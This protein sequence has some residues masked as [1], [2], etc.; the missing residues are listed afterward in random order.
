MTEAGTVLP[1]PVFW[2]TGLSGA[3]KTTIATS[4]AD[5]LQGAGRKVAILD[6]DAIRNSYD[7]PLGFTEAD[8]KLNNRL[9][10]EACAAARHDTDAVFVP[11]ISPYAES[12]VAARALLAPGFFEIYVCPPVVEL[13][14][15]DTKGLYAKARRGEM[16]NL[17]GY[18]PG[19]VYE[20]PDAPDLR[21]DTSAETVTES[22]K[23]LAA[24]AD[25]ILT[26]TAS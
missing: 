23:R 13:E 16:D 17:I 6:G 5:I 18:S 14:R 12:R 3:G 21:I 4:A 24:F 20:A 22:A 15:R 25:G 10:A 7:K 19:T 9:I 2:F 1:A 11:I 8:I 26:G